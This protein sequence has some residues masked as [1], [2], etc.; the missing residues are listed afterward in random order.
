M[1]QPWETPKPNSKQQNPDEQDLLPVNLIC[2]AAIV[3]TKLF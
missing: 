1:E 2:Q 3:V